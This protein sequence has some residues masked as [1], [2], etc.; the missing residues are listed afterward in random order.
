M[1]FY[2]DV[3]EP[4]KT[5]QTPKKETPKKPDKPKTDDA[6]EQP[7][8]LRKGNE[9][10][11]AHQ[12]D[13][14]YREVYVRTKDGRHKLDGYDPGKLIVSRKNVQLSEIPLSDGKNYIGEFKTK[15]SVGTLIDDR[16]PS[17]GLQTGG[18]PVTQRLNGTLQG[19]YILEVPVQTKPVPKEVLIEAK[20]AKVKVRDV[21]G[22]VYSL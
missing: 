4:S 16:V 8:Q 15:Y 11:D 3:P 7:E 6:K 19:E 10:D 20:G 13:Y 12:F 1:L 5:P 2:K 9:Y 18:Q 21:A 22:K 14:P 17:S